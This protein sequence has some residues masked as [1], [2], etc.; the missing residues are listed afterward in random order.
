MYKEYLFSKD[1]LYTEDIYP[2]DITIE[3]TQTLLE[4]AAAMYEKYSTV[5]LVCEGDYTLSITEVALN[6]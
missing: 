2:K 1:V 5:T 6:D 4:E 3:G